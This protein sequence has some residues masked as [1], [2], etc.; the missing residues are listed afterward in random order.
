MLNSDTKRH[1]DAARDVLVGVA[2]NPT[3][4]I[5]QITYALIYKFMDDMDQAA[6]KAGGEPSFFIGDLEQY[7]WS[8]LMD[9]R[10]GNQEKMNLY[11]EALVKFSEAKQ[12][13]ELFRTIFRSAFLPYRSPETLGL[14]LKEISYF[15]YTHPEELGNAYEY[16][17]SIMSSQGD[18]GQFRTPRHIIDFIVDV[19]NPTKDDKV[20]DPACGTGGFLVSTYNHILEQHDGKNDPNKK[21]KPLTPDERKKLMANLEGYDIDPTM[22]RIAQVN[23]YLHQ[24]KNPQIFQYDSLTSE[25]RW[26]DKFDVIL[27]N[28][29]FMSPKGG[30]KPHNKFGIASNR[31]EV[32]FV[33]YI[34]NHLRPKGKAGIIVPEG[35]IFQSGVAYKALRKNLVENG[36]YAVVS[37]PGGVFQ[38]YSGV[39]TS[40]LLLD[41]ELAKQKQEIAFVKI[42]ADGYDLGASKRAVSQNDLPVALE[43]LNSWASGVDV[44]NAILTLVNKEELAIKGEYNLSGD[45]YRIGVDH[46]NTMW[47]MVR[48][49]DVFQIESGGTPSTENSEFWD[50]DIPWATLVDI[51]KSI[52]KITTTARKI[53]KTGLANSSAKIMP[54]NTVLVSSRATIGRIAITDV[55]MATN[56]GFKNVIVGIE[57]NASYVAY[58]LSFKVEDMI[59]M[60]SGGTFKE[61]SKSSFSNLEIPLPPLEIQEQIVAEL[62]SFAAIIS[63]AKQIVDNWRPKFD[64]DPAWPV[65]KL[66]DL[67]E[68]ITKGTTP[69]T[70][71]YNFEDSGV[72]FL[73]VESI[74][75]NGELLPSKFS[76]VSPEC[77]EKL[78]RAQL[79]SNDVLFS[80]AGAL[81]RTA[82]VTESILPANINQNIATIRLKPDSDVDPQFLQ[83]SLG[84]DSAKKQSDKY[85]AGV[86]Q[87]VISL[88]Q[89][90]SYLLEIPPLEVQKK[91]V[92]SI[93]QE[94][95]LIK[96]ALILIE[97][98]EART[99]AAIAKLWSE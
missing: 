32:L 84:T 65:Y 95:N 49:G 12:L 54:K 50:G 73:K 78:K 15:D 48:I 53:S 97:T 35:V 87:Q 71:G 72:N 11:G 13:P 24:F 93:Q 99:K 96:S 92:E 30:I 61:I 58:A 25:D 81:G 94:K 29:P 14:F 89:L 36:L 80:I 1:I 5:D 63:G 44:N 19:L 66:S 40:I 56:Q 57:N 27:A 52:S 18:A 6:I 23:M 20:L 68:L 70:E 10:M 47:P 28:P 98:Y 90:G 39:K 91:I 77:H 59:A 76:H 26:N 3:T 37:L 16:L 83:Y 17:L 9:A 21:E 88:G 85:Q 60:A 75:E 31:S 4:Q 22:V 79:K 2:P 33:D 74:S 62:D 51:P 41:N 82:V 8:K 86:A 45:R 42:S 55:E 34:I 67:C 43:L 64:V 38:P 69:T 46:S 7:A